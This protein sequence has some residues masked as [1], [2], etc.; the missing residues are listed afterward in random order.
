MEILSGIA[1]TAVGESPTGGPDG[2]RCGVAAIIVAGAFGDSPTTHA[3]FARLG[4]TYGLCTL[5][6]ILPELLN[7]VA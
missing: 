3:A 2:K 6:P 5:R 4:A 1:G 7:A